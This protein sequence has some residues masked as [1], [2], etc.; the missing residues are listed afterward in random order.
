MFGAILLTNIIVV[1]QVLVMW[2]SLGCLHFV[3]QHSKH[4]KFSPHA[5]ARPKP[6][7]GMVRPAIHIDQPDATL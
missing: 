2:S 1:Q 4:F 7:S 3:T 6:P 5:T